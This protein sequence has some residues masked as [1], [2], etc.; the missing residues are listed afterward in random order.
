MRTNTRRANGQGAGTNRKDGSGKGIGR[1]GGL[2]RNRVPASK[3][4]HPKKRG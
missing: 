4:R 3:C 2:G 1:P